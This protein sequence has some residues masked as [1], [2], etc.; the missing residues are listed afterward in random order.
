MNN[1]RTPSVEI[2]S[3]FADVE[4]TMKRGASSIVEDLERKNIRVDQDVL[5]EKI[6]VAVYELL[7]ES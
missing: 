6:R 2:A 5:L 1:L 4:L 7:M 3:A